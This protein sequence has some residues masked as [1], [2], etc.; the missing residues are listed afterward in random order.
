MKQSGPIILFMC[1][2]MSAISLKSTTPITL[3]SSAFNNNEIIPLKHTCQGIGSSPQL[4]WNAINGAK[5][6]VLFVDDPDAP[7]TTYTHWIVY[8]IPANVTEVT[9]HLSFKT[10]EIKQTTLSIPE[11]MFPAEIGA[12]EGVNSSG[13]IHYVPPCPPMKRHRYYFTI[14]ALDT[15]LNL[16]DNAS[17][18]QIERS[19]QSHIIGKGIL[20]GT[21]QKGQI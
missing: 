2:F 6:Y 4:S 12:V 21:F 3:Q 7:G 8:N 5:S 16:P 13:K 10:D 11:N 15:T 17:Q 1:L 19:M 14:Y 18:Q 9:E 20:I